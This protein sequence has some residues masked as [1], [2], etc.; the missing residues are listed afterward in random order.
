MTAVATYLV[1]SLALILGS[2]IED[3]YH[4][5]QTALSMAAIMA[6][7]VQLMKIRIKAA[8][9]LRHATRRV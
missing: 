1:I 7:L 8:P 3:K 9:R 5:Y 6:L 2:D 4:L